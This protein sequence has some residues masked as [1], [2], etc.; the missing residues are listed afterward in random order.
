MA[1][2]TAAVGLCFVFSAIIYN[3][4]PAELLVAASLERNV[5]KWRVNAVRGGVGGGLA[6]IRLCVD[7]FHIE[8]INMLLSCYPA[9]TLTRDVWRRT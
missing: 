6:G 8:R 1:T 7:K 4:G 3:P 5:I 2:Y 9:C